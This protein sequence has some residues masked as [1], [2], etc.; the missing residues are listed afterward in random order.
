MIKQFTLSSGGDNQARISTVIVRRQSKSHIT[1]QI[2]LI[3]PHEIGNELRKS[4]GQKQV[5]QQSPS[6]EINS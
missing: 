5:G 3:S 1:V 6:P 2:I 4:S